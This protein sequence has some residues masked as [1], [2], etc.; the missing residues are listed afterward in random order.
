MDT[1]G[2]LSGDKQRLG[3]AYDFPQVC[4]WFAEHADLILVFFD[5]HKLDI[6][7]ELKEVLKVLEP[8]DD[9]IRIILNKADQ[10][11]KQELM[12]V[13]G[14]LM[15]SLGKIVST[16]EVPRVY[17]CSFYNHTPSQ[18]YCAN[19]ID[20]E[21]SDLINELRQL[22]MN[23]TTRKVNDLIKRARLARV[24]ALIINHLRGQMPSWYGKGAK[25]AK[26]IENLVGEFTKVQ[27]LYSIPTGDFPDIEEFCYKLKQHELGAFPKLSNKM[28][29][30]L[31]EAIIKDIPDLLR[32]YP[33]VF[34]EFSTSALVKNPFLSSSAEF[35]GQEMWRFDK[36]DMVLSRKAFQAQDPM[37]ETL[38]GPA[39]RAFFLQ[40][41]LPE[42]EMAKIWSLS[43][44]DN[45]GRLTFNEFAIMLHI[46]QLR[47][48][49]VEIPEE[50][51]ES[52]IPT[53]A[54]GLCPDNRA[55]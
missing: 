24:H 25:Q 34:G 5:A 33:P 38:D 42:E 55:K 44:L 8:H 7:D 29:T 45:D 51:P 3:R 26:L 15:W 36:I 10:V 39:C 49:N 47:I 23:S 17:I 22:P 14:A 28:L 11:G 16:P 32:Q 53:S 41:G 20:V 1:P 13:Y 43:D 6:S 9:K 46:T 40:S 37:N 21:R 12:R 54:D 2:V 31:E 35:D 27:Q 48:R 52:M 30:V 4:E 50:L 19:L 18:D